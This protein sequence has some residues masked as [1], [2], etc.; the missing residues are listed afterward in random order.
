MEW[1]F[2]QLA[3]WNWSQRV[4]RKRLG[5]KLSKN[6]L[7]VSL[8]DHEVKWFRLAFSKSK[9][10][11]PNNGFL[12]FSFTSCLL[13]DILRVW[14]RNL[15][16]IQDSKKE[17][18]TVLIKWFRGGKCLEKVGR[19]KL[20]WNLIEI[21]FIWQSRS[22]IYPSSRQLSEKFWGMNL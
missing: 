8:W 22:D 12:T 11:S 5:E 15:Q 20:F 14:V 6:P 4:R 1:L 2:F 13:I 21:C 16:L 17:N 18:S 9:P 19:F 7:L 3:C 10:T